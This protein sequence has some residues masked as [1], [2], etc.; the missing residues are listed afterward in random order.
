MILLS[1]TLGLFTGIYH[2]RHH[3]DHKF[4]LP[5][6]WIHVGAMIGIFALAEFIYRMN[7]SNESSFVSSRKDLL[8]ITVEN[9]NKRVE[10]GEALVI[11]DDLVLDI[12]K[13]QWDHPGG[14]FSLK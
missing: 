9:F 8:L 10:R 14:T 2:Y 11:L 1:A 6:E 4:D 12:K 5:L 7:F 13:Y 3:G